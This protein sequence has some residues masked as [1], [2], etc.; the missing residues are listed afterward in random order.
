[1][2]IQRWPTDPTAFDLPALD[3]PIGQYARSIFEKIRASTR[4]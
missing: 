3:I 4:P 1:M 2:A